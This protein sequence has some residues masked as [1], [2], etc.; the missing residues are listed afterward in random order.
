MAEKLAT[1][2]E[3]YDLSTVRA[4]VG[5]TK[6]ALLN[7]SADGLLVAG[8]LLGIGEGDH[9]TVTIQVL[10]FGKWRPMPVEGRVVRI[11]E[12][13]TAFNY[14]N[15]TRTWDRLLAALD[16]REATAH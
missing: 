5:G 13:G 7:V 2:A 4:L 11:D 3:R 1:R 12:R 15:A 14:R 6:H 9:C 8:E 10:A 16:R